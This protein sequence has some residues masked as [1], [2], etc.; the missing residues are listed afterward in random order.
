LKIKGVADLNVVES[1]ILETDGE[2]T[3]IY[4]EKV[5]SAA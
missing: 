5:K 4:K 2:L 1:I 3:I